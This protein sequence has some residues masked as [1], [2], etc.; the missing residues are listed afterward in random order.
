[1]HVEQ[2]AA[3]AAQRPTGN[4][5]TIVRHRVVEE[6]FQASKVRLHA[7]QGLSLRRNAAFRAGKAAGERVNLNR[8]VGQ[9]RQPLLR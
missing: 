3:V 2:E 9:G 5:L 4:A 1:M 8:P 6:A 7:Q